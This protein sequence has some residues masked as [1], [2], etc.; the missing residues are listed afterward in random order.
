MEPDRV[1]PPRIKPIL[2]QLAHAYDQARI[3][4]LYEFL[5]AYR[6]GLYCFVGRFRDLNA[7][8]IQ[9]DTADEIGECHAHV[10][11]YSSFHDLIE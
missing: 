4:Y 7:V 11:R 3:R 10:R 5:Q 9:R 2:G 8:V 1:F 6:T